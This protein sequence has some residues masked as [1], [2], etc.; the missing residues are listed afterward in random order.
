MRIEKIVKIYFL[1]MA[2][3]I[4]AAGFMQDNTANYYLSSV[5]HLFK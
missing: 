1:V 4:I 3:I 5:L 2:G